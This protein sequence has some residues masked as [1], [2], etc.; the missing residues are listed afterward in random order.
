L[1]LF[2]DYCRKKTY[3]CHIIFLADTET[4]MILNAEKSRPVHGSQPGSSSLTEAGGMKELG[5]FMPLNLFI[6]S[7]SLIV[8]LRACYRYLF[9]S[10]PKGDARFCISTDANT[11]YTCIFL[12]HTMVV[13]TGRR[14]VCPHTETLCGAAGGS[15]VPL[16]RFAM[17]IAE[18]IKK[19]VS[20]NP[21]A[22]HAVRRC[23]KRGETRKAR[24]IGAL[25]YQL[26]DGFAV[27]TGWF[28]ANV[29]IKGTFD[30]PLETFDPKK[31][32]ILFEFHRGALLR[33]EREHVSVEM[34][35]GAGSGTMMAQVADVKTGCINDLLIPG[36]NLK[37]TGSK[38]R[39]AGEDAGSGV[40]FVNRESG[41]RTKV[42]PTDIVVCNP[43]ELI[44]VMP[45]L[46][47][48]TYRLEATTQFTGSGGKLL[49]SPRMAVFDKA[50]TVQGV[51]TP[52]CRSA[53]LHPRPACC[54]RLRK[55]RTSRSQD[56]NP[57]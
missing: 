17:F 55:S 52:R 26:C 28:M 23:Q 24:R 4:E 44:V 25:D 13:I 8:L 41:E 15:F 36:R 40:R 7:I 43:S 37:I 27:N 9:F 46:E 53:A 1:L 56:D 2:V 38:I 49:N 22:L 39:I 34:L 29:H 35:G 33:K 48:G 31:H 50:L 6:L 19:R 32:G 21:G 57:E 51:C 11:R 30:G 14:P 18:K 47:A 12:K 54:V 3:L 20:G 10:F 16:P 5:F 45:L 42:D